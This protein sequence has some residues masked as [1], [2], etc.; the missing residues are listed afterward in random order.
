MNKK[1]ENLIKC[2]AQVT[3][4]AMIEYCASAKNNVNRE[5]CLQPFSFLFELYKI[6]FDDIDILEAVNNQYN[7]SLYVTCNVVSL[8][9][10]FYQKEVQLIICDDI[11][12]CG[13]IEQDLLLTNESQ[14]FFP[15]V[16]LIFSAF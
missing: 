8:Q 12:L 14:D 16:N 5:H 4:K 7:T 2:F 3:N 6:V 9:F 1:K 15:S 10:C 13:Y 11:T